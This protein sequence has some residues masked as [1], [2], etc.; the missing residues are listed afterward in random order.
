M[1][2]PR[3]QFTFLSPWAEDLGLQAMD[4]RAGLSELGR[5][6]LELLS[7]HADLA[8]EDLLGRTVTAS[9]RLREGQRCFHGH[10]TRFGLAGRQGRH[11]LYKAR[12]RPW[13]WFL[14]RT[15]DCR[16]FQDQSVP[17]IVK[18]VF[19]DHAG[20]AFE[21][22]LSRAYRRR[23]YCVQYRESD[24]SFVARL[25]EDEGIYWTLR[26]EEDRHVLVLQDHLGAHTPAPGCEALPY[27]EEA[28]YA[29]PDT[30]YITGWDFS[31]RIRPGRTTL[32]SYDFRKPGARLA[33]Q[34]RQVREHDLSDYEQFDF[35]G[36]YTDTDDGRDQAGVRIEEQQARHERLQARSNA[37]GL[38]EGGLFGLRR[39]PRDDQ[40]T[41]YLCL[42]T[43][44]RARS[45]GAEAGQSAGTYECRFSAIPANCQFRPARR[46]ERPVVKGPQTAV[47]VG[48]A[49]AEIHTDEY[50]RCRVQFHWDR[51]G[52]HDERSSCW[53]RVSQPWAGNGWGAMAIPRIGQEVIV[54]FLEGDPDQPVITGRLYNAGQMPPYPLPAGAHMTGLRSRSTPGG[55]G[56][57]ELV[58]HDRAG[59]ELVSIRSQKDM[60]TTVLNNQATV[61]QGPRQTIAVTTGMQATTVNKAIEV[62]SQTEGIRHTAHTAIEAVAQTAHILLQ[63]G[64]DIVLQVGKS[65]L[66]MNRDGSIVL[67][68]VQVTLKGSERVDVNP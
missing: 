41:Q 13:L 43:R 55:N 1:L 36:D 14:T 68:G 40:N 64:T 63:A 20:A 10:V 28:A 4:H 24:Y 23:T 30:E 18:T 45:D 27:I 66:Q 54:D 53:M 49:G 15:S 65:R 3:P 8:P 60:Q 7:P 34:A 11:F 59:Q 44:I 19:A 33:A 21:F 32:T 37:H 57:C 62:T 17:E 42:T 25:L 26:H 5:T 48:P 47:V 38:T 9:L 22:C 58:I 56:L 16:I 67:E 12:L 29:A 39:H 50:G 51:Y 46:T 35:Q 61:V 52:R 2:K 6:D 31:R